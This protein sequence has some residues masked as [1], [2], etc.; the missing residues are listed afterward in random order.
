MDDSLLQALETNLTPSLADLML[1]VDVSE[2]YAPKKISFEKVRDFVLENNPSFSTASGNLTLTRDMY[3][4][5]MRIRDVG[6]GYLDNDAVNYAQVKEG[7]QSLIAVTPGTPAIADRG[8]FLYSMVTTINNP[9]GGFYLFYWCVDTVANTVISLVNGTPV[10]SSGATIFA[11]GSIANIA[12]IHKESGWI[13]KYMHMAVRYRNLKSISDLGG[14]GHHAVNLP[15]YG[16]LINKDAPPKAEN[17]SIST[18]DNRLYINADLPSDAFSGQTYGLEL[19]FND[20]S[21]TEIIGNEIGL[22]RQSS[23]KCTYTYDI[24][25][26][27]AKYSYAHARIVSLSLLGEESCSETIHISVTID[28]A[29]ISDNLISYLAARVAEKVV[30]QNDEPLKYK[31]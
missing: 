18:A 24:P 8:G 7:I 22:I 11:E 10:A 25:I 4:A 1:I 30:T 14:T 21:D 6:S 15:A 12:N 5:G 2:S 23:S 26:S 31:L 19:L 9:W 28:G 29:A 13:G 20:D 16:D 3:A 17:L 27:M